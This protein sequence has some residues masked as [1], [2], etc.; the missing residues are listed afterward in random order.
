MAIDTYAVGD[1][2]VQIRTADDTLHICTSYDV[3]TGIFNQPSTFSVRLGD[4]STAAAL[5]RRFGP[6]TPFQLLV[7]GRPQ[8]SGYVEGRAADGSANQGTE[9]NLHG[10][11][12][13]AK[14]LTDLEKE[15]SFNGK[16]HRE[17]VEKA[18]A[19]LEIVKPFSNGARPS[20][21]ASNADARQA[22]SGTNISAYGPDDWNAILAMPAGNEG[23]TYPVLRTKL[24]E[25][26][27]DLIRKHLDTVGMF[28]WDS[29]TGDVIIGRPNWRQKPAAR[30][31]R[32]TGRA[33]ATNIEGHRFREDY[34]QRFSEIAVYGKTH[35]R[36]YNK[37]TVSGAFT[38]DE[39]VALGI[40]KVKVLRDVNVTSIAHA[41]AIAK[42][43][44]AAGR[45]A[46]FTLEYKMRGHT[47]ENVLTG[48]QLV[49]APDITV[50]VIDDELGLSGTY[51]LESCR[52]SRD[53]DG[54]H[55]TIKLLELA[56]LIFG[57]DDGPPGGISAKSNA[58][59]TLPSGQKSYFVA[60]DTSLTDLSL[61]LYGDAKH[62][63]NITSLNPTAYQQASP[64]NIFSPDGFYVPADTT[65]V[66]VPGAAPEG[67]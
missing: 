28:P 63:P 10:R 36:K 44:L 6:N 14:L 62:I 30:A 17:L 21:I 45:R 60:A 66:Y 5:L 40:H 12:I 9:I 43:H 11:S 57:D 65:I 7:G 8:F 33:S 22:R 51:Y 54:T 50:D 31:V 56:T 46:A 15:A 13:L 25:K 52:F 24:A 26:Y 53:K 39:I 61:Q 59:T 37:Y 55:T 41:E 23:D 47:T 34:S 27:L 1:D 2:R 35:G 4:G 64:H 3:Q 49:W 18:L 29:P 20:V 19:D 42:K 16:T 32:K 48:G 38:D 67:V 58:A